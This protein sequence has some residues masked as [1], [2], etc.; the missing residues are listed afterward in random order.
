[1]LENV[2][3]ETQS[4][5]KTKPLTCWRCGRII[6]ENIKTGHTGCLNTKCKGYLWGAK[7]LD[8]KYLKQVRK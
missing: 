6:W 5:D 4:K 2:T 7:N 1:M 3:T 8:K